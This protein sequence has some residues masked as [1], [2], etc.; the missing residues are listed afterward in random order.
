M[1]LFIQCLSEYLTENQTNSS[2]VKASLKVTIISAE[3]EVI[4]PSI[5]QIIYTSSLNQYS[6]VLSSTNK[7]VD[8]THTS[9][10]SIVLS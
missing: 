1:E 6:C 3:T 7:K 8:C 2:V 4:E 9:P 5:I 10:L